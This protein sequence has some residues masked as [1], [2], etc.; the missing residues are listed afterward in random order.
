LG[1]GVFGSNCQCS[2]RCQLASKQGDKREA[3]S[4]IVRN[5]TENTDLADQKEEL[6]NKQRQKKHVCLIVPRLDF[7]VPIPSH[8]SHV[9]LCHKQKKKTIRSKS[10]SYSRRICLLAFLVS[11]TTGLTTLTFVAGNS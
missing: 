5:Y 3:I 9:P 2:F 7:C 10:A 8:R 4:L 1:G 11:R 6:S